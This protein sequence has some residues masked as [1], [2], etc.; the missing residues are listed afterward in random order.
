MMQLVFRLFV[1]LSFY[2]HCAYLNRS[3]SSRFQFTDEARAALCPFVGTEGMRCFDGSP[4]KLSSRKSDSNYLKLPRGVG[5]TVDRRSGQLRAPAVNLTYPLEGCHTYWTDLSTGAMFDVFNEAKIGPANVVVAS[6]DAASIEVFR[7]ASQLNEAW[8]RSFADGNVRG[9]ELARPPDLL[10]YYNNYFK[11]DDALALSQ[12][13]IGLYTLT[14]NV[15]TVQLNSF[16]RQA[17]SQLTADSDPDVY[18]DFVDVWGTHIV[19]KS[20]VGG[21]VE[22]RAIVKRCFEAG[23]SP[24]F[25]QCI[26]FSDRN[27]NNFT[28]G[29]YA[30][31]TRVIS[32][33]HLGGNAEAENDKEWKRTLAVAPA[34]LQILEM[35]PWYDFVTDTAVKQ[36]LRTIIRY[37]QRN[38]DSVQAEAIRQVDSHLPSCPPFI[39]LRASS[40]DL[41]PTARWQQNGILVAG[42]NGQGS[43]NNQLSTPHGLDVDYDETVY[44]ADRYNHRIVEWKSS[45]TSGQVVAGGNGEGNRANQ[46]SH[47]LDVIIDKERD[48][49]IICDYGNSRVVRWPRRNGTSGETLISNINCVGLTMDENGSLYVVNNGG[50]EVRRY[51]RGDFQGTIVAGGNGNGNRLDQLL[52][53]TYVFV[54]R[55]HSLYVSDRDNHRVMKWMEGAKEGIVVAGGQ[56][57]GNGLIQLLNPHGVV[58]DQLGTTY[59]ADSYNHRI[60]RWLKGATHGSVIVGGNGQGGQSNQL[61]VPIGLSFDRHAETYTAYTENQ[62]SPCELWNNSGY[63]DTL[64]VQIDESSVQSPLNKLERCAV[65]CLDQNITASSIVRRFPLG[66]NTLGD[67]NVEHAFKCGSLT[68][69]RIWALYHLSDLCSADSIYIKEYKECLSSHKGHSNICPSPLKYY[70]YDGKI[71]WNVFLNYIEKL[72]L[73]EPLVLMDFDDGVTIDPSWKPISDDAESDSTS[74]NSIYQT[75][76]SCPMNRIDLNGYCYRTSSERKTI[77]EAK[78]KCI[79]VVNADDSKIHQEWMPNFNAM[80]NRM[81]DYLKGEIVHFTSEW[82]ARFGFFLLDASK[83]SK[84]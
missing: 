15:S 59:V 65:V 45:A 14:L 77:Q 67:S 54:D 58:V 10:A 84:G 41:H 74:M 78:E 5:M 73:I 25:T 4:M 43:I 7:N 23:N 16:A 32:T 81:N 56:G 19:T 17:V 35:V 42:G 51:R 36:N 21:M 46:L 29:Y 68:D 30:A 31:F 80:K 52:H 34:L 82:Q 70:G 11:R 47:P 18:E 69:P 26:P 60:M 40:I 49:L 63:Y 53:P 9:G 28:C 75:D 20:L 55:D 39:P 83:V 48:C 57:Q 27:P 71:T 8:R 6:Y 79:N 2:V 33:R 50:H 3:V 38:V 1:V 66:D 24:R 61:N 22:Q 12:R 76:R 13:V 72:K 44:I 37:R 62:F 64:H